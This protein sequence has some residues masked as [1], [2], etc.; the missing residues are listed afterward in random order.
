VL[1]TCTTAPLNAPVAVPVPYSLSTATIVQLPVAPGSWRVLSVGGHETPATGDY[2]ISF[3][4]GRV[5]A[6]FACNSMGGS[7]RIES[8][9]LIVADLAQTLMGCPEPAASFERD[10]S[11][12]LSRPMQ[13]GMDPATGGPVLFNGAGRINLI[14]IVS[15]K[16]I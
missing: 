13:I 2:S 15:G 4:D 3:A 9:V 10:G 6:R 7:Y 8:G 5:A 16:G 14:P 12:I 11:A 1:Q